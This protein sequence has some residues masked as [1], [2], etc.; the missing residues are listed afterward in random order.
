MPKSNKNQLLDYALT[1]AVRLKYHYK[2]YESKEKGLKALKRKVK[3]F[4]DEECQKALDK[5]EKLF[6]AASRLIDRDHTKLY[7]A[8]KDSFTGMPDMDYLKRSLKEKHSAF[9]LSTCG[10]ALDWAYY[11]IV[12]R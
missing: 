10:E 9:K 8:K 7:E 5:S 3:G 6:V 2:G 11:W 4:S 12:M 1:V